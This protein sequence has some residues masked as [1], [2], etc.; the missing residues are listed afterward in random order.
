MTRAPQAA[1]QDLFSYAPRRELW[2]AAF[3]A[4]ELMHLSNGH[5]AVAPKA[6]ARG[7]EAATAMIRSIK[8]GN[9]A[10]DPA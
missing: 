5:V 9:L 4:V 2:S 10:R 3:G 1:R 6:A 7:T 8:S